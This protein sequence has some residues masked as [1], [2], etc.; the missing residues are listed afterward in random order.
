MPDLVA[1]VMKGLL[2]CRALLQ[3]IIFF[4]SLEFRCPLYSVVY[5][6]SIK[7]TNLETTTSEMTSS[8]KGALSLWPWNWTFKE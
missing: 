7:C 2:L 4:K 6:V 8:N 3:T 5:S 1:A